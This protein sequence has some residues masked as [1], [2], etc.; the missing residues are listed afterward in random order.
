MQDNVKA[1]YRLITEKLGIKKLVMVLGWSM[2]AGQT[3][4]WGVRCR[5]SCPLTRVLPCSLCHTP[6]CLIKVCII[7]KHACMA[8]SCFSTGPEG[9]CILSAAVPLWNAL[10][11]VCNMTCAYF[12]DSSECKNQVLYTHRLCKVTSSNIS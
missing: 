4:Q 8:R 1:Q 10:L 6:I 12:V 9:H 7:Y 11:S 3:F 5:S 2:G